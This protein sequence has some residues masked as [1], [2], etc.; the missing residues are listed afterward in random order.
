MTAATSTSYDMVIKK[1]V[2]V[3]TRYLTRM[4]QVDDS[5]Q[6]IERDLSRLL[7]GTTSISLT[8]PQD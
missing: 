7:N 5:I 1:L 4:V 3:T 2:V 8:Y 6:K